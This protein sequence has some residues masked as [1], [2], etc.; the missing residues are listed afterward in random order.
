MGCDIHENIEIKI[1]NQWVYIGNICLYR[2]Y[3][4]FGVLAGVRNHDIEPVSTPKGLPNNMSK[5][6][7]DEVETYIDKDFSPENISVHE[8]VGFHSCS[9]LNIKELKVAKEIYEEY[10]GEDGFPEFLD[11]MEKLNDLPFVND[12]RMVFWFDN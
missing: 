1:G 10:F 8:D 7:H 5:V 12:V 4:L 9:Y 2:N 6:I 3:A 11:E